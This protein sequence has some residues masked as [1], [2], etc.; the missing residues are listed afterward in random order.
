MKLITPDYYDDF[1]CIADRCKHSCCIG[2]EIDIDHK[3]LD[4]YNSLS[5][6][7]ADVIRNSIKGEESPYFELGCDRRCPHLNECGLC[8]IILNVGENYL[9]DICREHPRFYNF[10]NMG[11]ELGLGMSC[12]EACRLIL[13]SDD[14]DELIV[15]DNID[16]EADICEFDATVQRN[17]I[18]EILKQ[19]TIFSNKLE[20]I[21]NS[22]HITLNEE[23][24]KVCL[25]SLEYLNKS[26]K[27]LFA[28][29]SLDASFVNIENELTRVLAY[30]IYRHC[31][32]ALDYEEFC[33]SLFFAIVC[34]YLVASISNSDNIIERA[35]TVSEEIEY[36]EENTQE[37]ISLYTELI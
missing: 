23:D 24:I 11:K 14:F 10:T 22:Y 15:I 25:S 12:E 8:N 9:C 35:R 26:N 30:F 13:N 27:A 29:F 1:I 21:I 16:G 6:S 36:S 31:S 2:W 19:D 20:R 17:K 37:I 28:A 3:T 4:A 5:S 32:E 33:E 34:T 7:Y 18:Y